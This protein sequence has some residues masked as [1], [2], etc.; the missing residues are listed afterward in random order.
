MS[1]QLSGLGV[2]S[3]QL[4]AGSGR[5]L[6]EPSGLADESGDGVV[7]T[8]VAQAA[9][10]TRTAIEAATR[11]TRRYAAT[12]IMDELILMRSPL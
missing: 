6:V 4:N 2:E 1:A 11:L 3:S 5:G 12:K 8:G 10:A 9:R 7:R